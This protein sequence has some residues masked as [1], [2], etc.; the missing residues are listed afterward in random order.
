[1]SEWGFRSG[2]TRCRSSLQ[3]SDQFHLSRLDFLGVNVCP[4]VEAITEQIQVLR[5]DVAFSSVSY[6][7]PARRRSLKSVFAA[8]ALVDAGH[9]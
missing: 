7:S 1:M 8:G 2:I 4:V 6:A 3:T 9:L 5:V